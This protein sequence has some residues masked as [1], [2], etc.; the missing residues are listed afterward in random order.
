MIDIREATEQ[1]IP[2]IVELLKLSLGETLMPKSEQYW[3]WK[4]IENPFGASPVSLAFEDDV[5]IGVRAFL[6]WEWQQNQAVFRALRAV[7]TATHPQFQ[8]KGTFRKLTLNLAERCEADGDHFIFNTPNEKSKPG[9]LKMGWSEGGRLPIMANFRRPFHLL[10][11]VVLQSKEIPV[12][13]D[14]ESIRYY[15]THPGLS[16]L[17]DNAKQLATEKLFTRFSPTYLQ[18]RY[19]QVPVVKYI[20][21]GE[22]V[23][24]HLTGLVIA[25]IK[26]TRFGREL[27]ITD[28][29][30]HKDDQGK[31]LVKKLDEMK[32]AL[33]IDYTTM[34]GIDDVKQKALLGRMSFKLP[35]G[36]IVTVR[37]LA[38]K[39]ISM[40]INFSRWSPSIGDLELF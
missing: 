29:F 15:L 1:D 34:S 37:P 20:A 4:H 24:S 22:E 38:L 6:R 30:I 2:S 39:D 13:Q 17:L 10:K 31:G 23:G 26:Q 21:V 35:A 27:R 3:R 36:P 8:G 28:C 5:L 16:A 25:R 14:E 7:D 33:K 32:K 12:H 9:Y 40:L 19:L 18:W 11:N